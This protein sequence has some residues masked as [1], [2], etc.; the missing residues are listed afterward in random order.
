MKSQSFKLWVV[1]TFFVLSAF[2]LPMLAMAQLVVT[3]QFHEIVTEKDFGDPASRSVMRV[4]EDHVEVQKAFGGGYVTA[5][6]LAGVKRSEEPG[7]HWFYYVN[8]VL[9]Q[10]G[11]NTY[12]P[13]VD[14]HIWWDRHAWDGQ[15]F[16]SALIGAWPEPFLSGYAKH[17]FPTAIWT[18]PTFQAEAEALERQLQTQGVLQITHSLLSPDHSIDFEKSFPIYIGTWEQLEHIGSLSDLFKHGA[19]TGLFIAHRD[20]RLIAL[21]WQGKEGRTYENA[22]CILALKSPFNGV[23]PIW[24]ISGTTEAAVKRALQTLIQNPAAIKN[25]PGVI[26]L[27]EE[28][29]SV[30][31]F[32]E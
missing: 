29:V 27:E 5:I 20:N 32:L 28:M 6:S 4:L 3:D 19:R 24:V 23:N 11:A 10:V 30:P 14:D 13:Q 12:Y 31:A 9:A 22:G 7:E 18:T 21:N 2:C 26:V 1:S 25:R 16:V 8:G 17:V 15:R